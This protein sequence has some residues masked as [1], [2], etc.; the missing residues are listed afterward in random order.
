MLS[1]SGRTLLNLAEKIRDGRLSATIALVIASREC[2]GAQR[3]RELGIDTRVIKGAIPAGRL[4]AILA[5]HR[6][7]WVALAGYLRLVNIP[8]AYDKRIVNIHPALLP[9][10]G[11]PGMY[12]H[13][14]HKAVLAAGKPISGCTVHLCDPE[15]DHGPIILQKSCPVLAGD[16]PETLG[17]RVFA[18]ECEAYPEALQLLITGR[19][20]V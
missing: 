6:I 19:V 5:E 13:H 14:V 16:T 1:G 11:G 17:A 18:L 2:L 20:Q 9:D 4:A 3:A 15:Y 12:G 8:P 7:D 10:F